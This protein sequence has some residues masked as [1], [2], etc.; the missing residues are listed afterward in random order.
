[1]VLPKNFFAPYMVV[2]METKEAAQRD[3]AAAIHPSDFTARPQMVAEEWNPGYYRMIKAFERRTGR[4]GIL[5][6]S[7]NIHGEPI[8]MT[9]SDAY[10]TFARSDLDGVAIGPVFISRY[11]SGER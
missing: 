5:N 4:G 1:M 8:A 6:T 9:A 2:A 7:F 3:L 11:Q 10:D